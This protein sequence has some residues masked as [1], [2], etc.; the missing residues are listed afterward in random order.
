MGKLGT[1]VPGILGFLVEQDGVR[2]SN[3]GHILLQA[4][5]SSK[6]DVRDV[7]CYLGAG[8]CVGDVSNVYSM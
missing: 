7:Y 3:T 4:D 8:H 6:K 1:K 5:L 2:C